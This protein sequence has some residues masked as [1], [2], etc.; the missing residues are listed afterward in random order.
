VLL[1]GAARAGELDCPEPAPILV[2]AIPVATVCPAE[3]PRL[4]L[5]IVSLDD[6]WAP[7]PLSPAGFEPPGYRAAYVALANQRWSDPAMPP[8]AVADGDFELFGIPPSFGVVRVRLG[9]ELRHECH[10]AV[11]DEALAA[12]TGRLA[13]EEATPAAERAAPDRRAAV[14]AL[15]EH[16]VCERLL[17]RAAVDGRWGPTTADALLRYRR[18]HAIPAIGPLDPVTAAALVADSRELDFQALL[19]GLRERVADAAGLIEDGS[20]RGEWQPVLGRWLDAPALRDPHG[21]APLADGAPD[22]VSPATERAARA[23]GFLDPAAA[24]RALDRLAGTP[25]VAVALPTAPPYHSAHMELRAEIDRGDVWYQ[26]PWTATGARRAQPVAQR[27]VLILWAAD[28]EDEVALV[29]WPTT[30]GGWQREQ[31]PSR[32]V[33]MRYKPSMPGAY[34]WRDLVAAPVWF[35][36]PTTPDREL[37]RRGADGRWRVREETVGP[38]YRSAYGLVMLLH[39]HPRHTKR[40]LELD[41]VGTRTHGTGSYLG[42]PGEGSHGCHRLHGGAALRLGTFVLAHRAHQVLGPI[43]EHYGRVVRAGGRALT[44]ARIGRGYRY[45]LTPPIDVRVLEGRV[46]GPVR[47][48]L[49]R[50][51]PR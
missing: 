17:A 5:T 14:T 8:E 50:S 3:A 37:V 45:E 32:A 36:P 19:R 44:I 40:G 29:R 22:L 9:D 34:L 18:R 13:R 48:P 30:I 25:R 10:D 12:Y 20:A 23:L 2:E 4:G 42:V 31:L 46:L 24:R 7:R 38:S 39:H 6:D 33:V 15:Q 35:P 26:V 16:L 51:F 41:D 21:R 43:E 47:A 49:L 11:D 28:G 1:P 27:P